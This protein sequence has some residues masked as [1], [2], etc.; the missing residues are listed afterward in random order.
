M[1]PMDQP[2]AAFDMINRFMYGKDMADASQA[3]V[4]AAT[5]DGAPAHGSSWRAGTAAW[6]GGLRLP[7]ATQR[8]AAPEQAVV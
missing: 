5:P 3:F 1:V 4:R 7:S 2:S 8:A 6:S